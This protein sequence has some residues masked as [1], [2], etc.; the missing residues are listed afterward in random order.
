MSF[1]TSLGQA[2]RN[3]F[4]TIATT[5]Q[6]FGITAEVGAEYRGFAVGVNLIRLAQRLTCNREPSAGYAPEFEGGQCPTLYAIQADGVVNRP[7]PAS[8]L[9]FTITI[10][11]VLGPISVARVTTTTNDIVF[12]VIAQPNVANPD[13]DYTEV[14]FANAVPNGFTI[15]SYTLTG[16]NRQDGLP[17]DCG[18]AV[19]PVPPSQPGQR[20]TNINFT[21]TDNSSN[22]IDIDA[23][24]TFG[25]IVLGINGDVTIPFQVTYDDILP[26]TFNGTLN[27]N[28]GDIEYSPGNK[29]YPPSKQPNGDGYNT[30]DPPEPLPDVPEDA[31]PPSANDDE[32]EYQRVIRGAFVT[33]VT[34]DS[35]GTVID[36]ATAPDIIAPNLGYINFAVAVS[37]KVGWTPDIPVKNHRFFCECPWVGGAI[38]VR[39]TPRPGVT[40]V[41]TPVYAREEKTQVFE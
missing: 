25:D 32:P 39:G 23:S 19:P 26:F 27:L 22:D 15:D 28:T 12:Q 30:D 38:E 36:Q 4:C 24:V 21:Y 20:T 8:P 14:I 40:W 34:D 5:A 2:I 35:R 7:A 10:A 33:V 1:A 29:G 6:D 9:S 31:I 13:G 37:D 18:N 41:I 17:D 16:P 3:G 11:N